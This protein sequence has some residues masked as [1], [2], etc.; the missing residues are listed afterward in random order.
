MASTLLNKE[1]KLAVETTDGKVLVLAGAGSGKT[2]VLIQRIAYLIEQKGV[3]PSKIL[4][5]TFTNKAA[6]EMRHR[7]AKIATPSIAKQVQLSTFHSFCYQLLRKEIHRLGYT[8]N[9][10]LVDETE[11]KRI[12][13]HIV[14]EQ[15]E[16]EGRLPSISSTFEAL[17]T[18]RIS[19]MDFGKS[20]EKW[21]DKL[22]KDLPELFKRS[23]RAY[24]TVDFD[25]LIELSLSLFKENPT[26]LEEYQERFSYIMIDEYQDTSPLQDELAKLLASKKRNLCVVGDDDQSIYAFRGAKVDQILQFSYDTII[27]LEQNY[28]STPRILSAAN[29][30]IQHNKTRHTKAL[31]SE[32]NLGEE[33]HVFVSDDENSEADGVVFRILELKEQKKLRWKDFAILYRSNILSR[34][35]ELALMRA[36]YKDENGDTR[37]SIPY[38]IVQGTEFYERREVKDLLAYMR[39]LSNPKDETALLR[40][41]NT[42]RRG[43]SHDSL[44]KITRFQR[45]NHLPLMHVLQ[46]IKEDTT[47]IPSLT[48]KAVEG[49]SS[50]VDLYEKASLRLEAKQSPFRV[51]SDLVEQIEYKKMILNEVKTEKAENFKIEN[52]QE[53]LKMIERY[54]EDCHQSADSEPTLSDFLAHSHLD[55]DALQRQDN[56]TKEDLVQLLTFHS[57]KGLEFR[58]CFLIGLEDHILPHEKS[59]KEGGLEE[60]RRLFY[61]AITRAMEYLTLSMATSRKK[62]GQTIA[63]TPSRFLHE[64]NP[65]NFKP[66]VW[67]H[68]APYTH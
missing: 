29:S 36:R 10:T 38:H 47:L 39:V 63:T 64:I 57:A 66:S 23:M 60:E 59:L 34:P 22:L 48:S 21:H 11:A 14:R 40:I 12:V 30:V 61:V 46:K 55:H 45:E 28:R 35:I 3:L 26:L 7:L 65:E 37:S 43:I 6:L 9:F 50:F 20:G 49:V 2:S 13:E 58:A 15:L 41:I 1:Q 17:K 52:V 19:P 5:L 27:K 62:M 68:P 31:W 56:S 8:K 51:M 4:G 54:E 67:K 32:K 24:N 42:P 33:L 44:E 25:G 16:F 18:T 53:T